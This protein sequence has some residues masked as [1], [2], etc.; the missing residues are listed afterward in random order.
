MAL[1]SNPP[2]PKSSQYAPLNVQIG[3]PKHKQQSQPLSKHTN[4]K[5][6]ENCTK[7]ISHKLLDLKLKHSATSNTL[8]SAYSDSE[9][10]DSKAA[11]KLT[12]SQFLYNFGANEQL[13]KQEL[14]ESVLEQLKIGLTFLLHDESPLWNNEM[15]EDDD[16]TNMKHSVYAKGSLSCPSL[17]KNDS[18]YSVSHLSHTKSTGFQQR[19]TQYTKSGVFGGFKKNQQR[20]NALFDIKYT[21]EYKSLYMLW[22]QWLYYT[23]LKEEGGGIIAGIFIN[24]NN[25]NTT[26]W[27]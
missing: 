10:S 17:A 22:S 1:S 27:N 24:Y 19:C 3:P 14:I 20:L 25:A 13:L 18:I 23:K 11:P 6:P 2:K 26:R 16:E 12:D 21:E 9:S 5:K 8:S 7:S 15:D 4:H